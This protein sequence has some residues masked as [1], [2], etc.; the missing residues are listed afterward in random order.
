V[1]PNR[2]QPTTVQQRAWT[3]PIWFSPAAP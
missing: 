2:E 3:S 1:A